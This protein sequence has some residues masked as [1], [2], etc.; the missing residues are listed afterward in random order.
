MYAVTFTPVDSMNYTAS[1]CEAEVRVLQVISHS[2]TGTLFDLTQVTLPTGVT[3]VTVS[4]SVEPTADVDNA[5]FASISNMVNADPNKRG[6]VLT[7]YDLKLLDQAGNQI[8]NFSGAI[9]VKIPIPDGV[10]GNLHVFWYNP[11]A[12]TMTDMNAKPDGDW[13]V[14]ETTHFS[15][16]AIVQMTGPA[17][18]ETVS[19]PDAGGNAILFIALLLLGLL[20]ILGV[21]A[22]IRMRNKRT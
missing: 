21:V 10:S 7:I 8:V 16:Y 12:G 4:L 18:S 14:F 1:T 11:E 3:S 13:L 17:S 22:V 6:N 5:I 9:T 20:L 15:Y 2:S 19:N